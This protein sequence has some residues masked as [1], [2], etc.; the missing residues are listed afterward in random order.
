MIHDSWTV[1][2]QTVFIIRVSE[3][4]LGEMG[5]NLQVRQTKSADWLNTLLHCSFGHCD[6]H[7][8]LRYNEKNVFCIDCKLS[9]CR[10]CKE[11]HTLHRRFQIYKYVYQDVVRHS[12]LQK[13]FNCSKIQVHSFFTRYCWIYCFGDWLVL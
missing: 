4:L 2:F 11:A 7:Q 13:F 3:F 8:D 12:D 9:L 5:F 6:E 10:H 1:F